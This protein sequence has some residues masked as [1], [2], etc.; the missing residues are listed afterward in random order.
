M[1]PSE[2]AGG[3]KKKKEKE[4]VATAWIVK[5]VLSIKKCLGNMEFY[6]IN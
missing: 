5:P 2:Y 6:E 1:P 4:P 3:I